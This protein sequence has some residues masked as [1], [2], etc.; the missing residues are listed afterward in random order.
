MVRLG[1]KRVKR[2]KKTTED[3]NITPYFFVTADSLTNSTTEEIKISQ[4]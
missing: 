4:V 2:I 1:T 3:N